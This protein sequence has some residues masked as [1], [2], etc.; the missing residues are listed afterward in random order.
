MHYVTTPQDQHF[1]DQRFQKVESQNYEDFSVIT[2]I[3][4]S[5]SV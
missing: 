3:V 2:F 4:T 1:N 5:Q